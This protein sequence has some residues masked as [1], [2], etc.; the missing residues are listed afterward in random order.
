VAANGYDASVDTPIEQAIATPRPLTRGQR[1]GIWV[2]FHGWLIGFVLATMPDTGSFL[3]PLLGGW[4]L[5]VVLALG[6]EAVARH[7]HETAVHLGSVAIAMG[8][9]LVYYS[10]AVEPALQGH[11]PALQRLEDLGSVTHLPAW[12]GAAV[13]AIGSI[14]LLRFAI[15]RPGHA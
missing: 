14:V 12:V 15:R 1:V 10:L 5:T 2:G 4:A 13:V 11:P 6:F 3:G 8:L 7:T 9:V